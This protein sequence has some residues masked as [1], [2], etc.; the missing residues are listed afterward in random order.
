[1]PPLVCAAAAAGVLAWL[2]VVGASSPCTEAE[3]CQ[4]FFSKL[5]RLGYTCDTPYESIH[6]TGKLAVCILV[7]G[8][9]TSCGFR[10]PARR[11]YCQRL[12][13]IL[14]CM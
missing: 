10:S 1:M 2:A 6:A 4:D 12:P 5:S 14:R 8:L 7:C 9:L 13:R 11:D 3:E